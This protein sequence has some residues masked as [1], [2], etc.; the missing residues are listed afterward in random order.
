MSDFVRDLLIA[1]RALGNDRGWVF[2]G[3]SRSG[4]LEE[5]GDTLDQIGI[6]TGI[7][8]TPHDLRRTF[9][10]VAEASDISGYALKAMV[11]HAAGSDVTGRYVQISTERLRRAVQQVAD[12]MKELCG[13]AAPTGENLARFGE[14]G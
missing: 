4:H 9:V 3:N 6:D 13:I 10:T 5:P 7:R 12:R 8:V 14:R 1:R 11:N 2:G